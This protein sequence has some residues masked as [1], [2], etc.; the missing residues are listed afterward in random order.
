MLSWHQKHGSKSDPGETGLVKQPSD[1]T[2]LAKPPWL[3]STIISPYLFEAHSSSFDRRLPAPTYKYIELLWRLKR[4][5]SVKIMREVDRGPTVSGPSVPVCF[6]PGKWRF[7]EPVFHYMKPHEN[8]NSVSLS[9]VSSMWD[10]DLSLHTSPSH[11]SI[12][13]HGSKKNLTSLTLLS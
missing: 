2:V 12:P 6:M 4:T 10:P 7:W 9:W 3:P 11:K 13:Y 5:A 1:A 8:A